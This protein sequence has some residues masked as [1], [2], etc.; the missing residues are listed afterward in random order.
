MYFLAAPTER[1]TLYFKMAHFLILKA[2]LTISKKKKKKLS[3][4][5]IHKIKFIIVAILRV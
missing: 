2:T 3:Y 5:K 4:G 1:A